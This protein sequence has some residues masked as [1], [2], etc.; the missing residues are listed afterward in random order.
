MYVMLFVRNCVSNK[1]VLLRADMSIKATAACSIES[2][3]HIHP[4]AEEELGTSIK[5]L[6]GD[7]CTYVMESQDVRQ[8]L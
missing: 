7:V 5:S 4:S 1:N 3:V 2:N 8:R 6:L